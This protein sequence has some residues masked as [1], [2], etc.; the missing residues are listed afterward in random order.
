MQSRYYRQESGDL[1][2]IPASLAHLCV[3]IDSNPEDLPPV[4]HLS[5]YGKEA[6]VRAPYRISNIALRAV[7]LGI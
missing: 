3:G 4:V 2:A 7:P 1:R 6:P 5:V